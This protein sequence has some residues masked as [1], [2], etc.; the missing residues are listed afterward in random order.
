MEVIQ[1]FSLIGTIFSVCWSWFAQIWNRSGAM[2]YLLAA[3]F[4]TM[5]YRFF[6]APLIA[7]SGGSDKAKKSG[8]KDD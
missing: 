4:T 6:L 3:I 2:G 7:G 8:R 1:A 5:V